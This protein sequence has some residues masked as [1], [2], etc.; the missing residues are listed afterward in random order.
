M[1]LNSPA[2]ALIRYSEVAHDTLRWKL[3]GVDEYDLRRPLTPTGTNLLGVV[4]HL[5]WVELEY[6]GLVFDRPHPFGASPSHDVPNSDMY[7]TAD[8]SVDDIMGLLDGAQ[9]QMRS[10]LEELPLD[11]EGRVPWWGDAGNPVT[12]HRIAVHMLAE[13]NRHVGQIDILR[14]QL[15]GDAGYRPGVTN[16]PGPDEFDWAGYCDQLE[17]IA[18]EA[19]GRS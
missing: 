7:A 8:E 6:F 18:R 12:L 14:E 5:G 10:A 9:A 15:D 4:K 17:A 3:E 2:T 19:T 16:M 1:D 11:H 13:I